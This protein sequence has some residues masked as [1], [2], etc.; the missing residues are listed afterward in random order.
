MDQDREQ[1]RGAIDRINN[2]YQL[3]QTL[4]AAG[5]LTGT[6]WGWIIL[7]A[8]AVITI[9]AVIIL[10]GGQGAASETS[11][12]QA[13]QTTGTV[14]TSS[15]FNL[16]GATQTSEEFIEIQNILA[17]AL[18]YPNYKKLLTERGAINLT[19]DDTPGCGAKVNEKGDITFISFEH[20]TKEFRR[21][22]FLHE[23][24]HII[25]VRNERE[26]QSFDLLS[27]KRG[28]PSCYTEDGYLISYSYARSVL[29]PRGE[30]RA[31]SFA[32]SIALFLVSKEPLENFS[33]QCP[34][35][36]NWVRENIFK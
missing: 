8:I 2:V 22:A 7:G 19:F 1:R 20:C 10:L 25:A 28:D 11:P 34:N 12:Q 16:T 13:Q 15:L 26:W 5:V 35:T 3:A 32:E 33:T 30:P 9:F 23:T 14:E 27:F 21:Y 6:P 24:G 31:E 36:Y 18:S 17:P 4:R 29:S